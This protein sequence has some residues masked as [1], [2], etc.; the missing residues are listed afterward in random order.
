MTAPMPSART[1][2]GGGRE[3]LVE[4]RWAGDAHSTEPGERLRVALE[5]FGCR[6]LERLRRPL[7]VS[8]L[9]CDETVI[10][11]LNVRYRGIDAPTDVLSFGQFE[12]SALPPYS[13]KAR[14]PEPSEQVAGDVVI[15]VDVAARQ[16]A[17]RGEPLEREL[18][19]LLVHGMLHLVGM[20][21]ADPPADD[22]P[23]LTLQEQVLAEL[24]SHVGRIRHVLPA[25]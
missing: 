21:H 14:G 13:A 16:A 1:A 19:R 25:R 7:E 17:V 8:V 9:L 20:D 6:A 24:H 15:A 10:R 11:D 5:R 12:E 18:C 23:M 4:V 2:G 3:P 22:E